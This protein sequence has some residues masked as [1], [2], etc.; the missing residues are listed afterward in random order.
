MES[1]F[2]HKYLLV[3][4]GCV[5]LCSVSS[6][7]Y[8]YYDDPDTG[9]RIWQ[10]TT[11]TGNN[12]GLYYHTN[13]Q[14]WSDMDYIVFR[15]MTNTSAASLTYYR[16]HLPTGQQTAITPT[17]LCNGGFV[18]GNYL[19]CYYRPQNTGNY[20]KVVKYALDNF[21][22]T[23]ICDLDSGWTG[24]G[25]IT[26]NCNSTYLLFM[27]TYSTSRQLYKV[28][29]SDGT[30]T[31]L[32]NTTQLIEH[33][34]FHTT[35]WRWYNYEN[36]SNSGLYRVGVGRIDTNQN[37]GCYS[38][39]SFLN[40]IENFSHPFYDANGA[41]CSDAIDYNGPQ[42]YYV[43]FGLDATNVGNITSYQVIPITSD[44]W[45]IHPGPSDSAGWIAGGG[46]GDQNFGEAYIHML[47]LDWANS[48]ATQYRLANAV[49]T[50]AAGGTNQASPHYIV[51][52]YNWVAWSAFRTLA[53]SDSTDQNIFMVEW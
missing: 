10:L 7:A 32:I 22:R 43:I 25:D 35:N 49:G 37:S 1:R 36:Q 13:V 44:K 21:A 41:L 12:Y 8:N 3:L 33:F 24:G 42:Y 40:N 14:G 5:L 45:N 17:G 16:L 27:Q 38:S 11:V 15:N 6:Y 28:D 52:G 31:R 48:T 50:Y 19:Y 4:L 46:K 39:Y 18:K 30:K 20:T 2:V 47:N 53:G 23:D 9:Y 29:L 34:Q 51:D 26:V